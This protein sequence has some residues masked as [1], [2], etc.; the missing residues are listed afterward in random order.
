[1]QKSRYIPRSEDLTKLDSLINDLNSNRCVAFV[2][3]GVSVNKGYRA[4]KN[5]IYDQAKDVSLKG[6]LET[7]GI[8][9][10]EV[11]HLK[12]YSQIMDYCKDK[13]EP[14]DFINFLKTEYSRKSSEIS[15][16]HSLICKTNFKHIITTNFD[17]CLYDNAESLVPDL[18]TF[19]ANPLEFNEV[20][21]LFQLHGRAYAIESEDDS[22]LNNLIGGLV[23][24]EKSFLEAY[25]EGFEISSF[26]YRIMQRFKLV[27][28]GYSMNDEVFNQ[29][30]TAITK[31]YTKFLKDFIKM[32][33]LSDVNPTIGF[34][35]LAY[36]SE[37]FEKLKSKDSNLDE[38]E[39]NKL[40]QQI[41]L[42]QNEVK[43]IEEMRLQVIGYDKFDKNFSGLTAVLQ[44]I[45]NSA[46]MASL[47]KPF[48]TPDA[49]ITASISG[50]AI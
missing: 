8:S 2:G 13:M 19:G 49:T 34:V 33:S 20:R 42:F 14:T 11:G 26:L 28:I 3:A 15:E 39:K 23:F 9:F 6:L 37:A 45:K 38:N 44:L 32:N 1:M 18:K 24:G 50:S 25:F 40:V 21:T 4:W 36:P 10:K 48:E 7:A 41:E 27:F 5:L 12:T 22:R 17:P 35:L 47:S 31:A 30:T 46:A 16:N 29:A 43:R